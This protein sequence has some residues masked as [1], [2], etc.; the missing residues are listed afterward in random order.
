MRTFQGY[1][2]LATRFKSNA[3]RAF[4]FE[5][6]TNVDV[7]IYLYHPNTIKSDTIRIMKFFLAWG[8]S[9]LFP[10]KRIKD[11]FFYSSFNQ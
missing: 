3:S 6:T 7:N 2:K 9:S 8:F 4:H 11:E 10:T 1:I 5:S